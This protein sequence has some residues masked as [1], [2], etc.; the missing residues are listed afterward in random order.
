[1]DQYLT[2]MYG[3]FPS[4]IANIAVGCFAVFSLLIVLGAYALYKS[5]KKK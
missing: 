4:L 1:M 5:G 3:A 2:V